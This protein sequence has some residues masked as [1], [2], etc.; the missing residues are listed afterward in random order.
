MAMGMM[1][2]CAIS[3]KP[4]RDPQASFAAS[5]F[6]AWTLATIFFLVTE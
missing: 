1:A 4:L 6:I 5:W 2:S 3:D